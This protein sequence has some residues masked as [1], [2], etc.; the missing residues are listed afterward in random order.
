MPRTYKKKKPPPSYSIKDLQEAVQMVK[1]KKMSQ[2]E[3][4]KKYSI[5]KTVIQLRVRNKVNE[6]EGAE[7]PK[8]L[9][10]KEEGDIVECLLAR[11]K[12]GYPCDK[13][14]LLNLVG[15]YVKEY[16]INNAFKEGIPG[17]DWYKGFMKRHPCL[18]LKK[19]EHIQAVRKLNTTP[20]VV[21]D[22]YEKLLSVYEEK[23]LTSPD[24][25]CFVFNTDESGFKSDPSRLRGI[26]GFI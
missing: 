8:T 14:E 9:T 25:A 20:E 21:Y 1:E 10:D 5:P 11:A 2:C 19:A 3:A 24:K 6:C 22:F 23:N 15:E 7:R 13:K 12:F 4:Q 16:R 26:I 18:S 17:Q